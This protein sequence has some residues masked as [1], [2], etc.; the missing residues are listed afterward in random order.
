MQALL[1]AGAQLDG[2]SNFRTMITSEGQVKFRLGL[3]TG[4]FKSLNDGV[5]VKE[6]VLSGTRNV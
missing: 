2:L 6:G 4:S 5:W 3:I 1:Q